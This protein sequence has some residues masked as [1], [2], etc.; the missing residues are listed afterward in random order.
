MAITDYFKS[1]RSITAEEVREFL[2]GK[3]PDDYNLVDVRQ[4]S[5]YEDGHIPGSRLIPL[6]ELKDRTAELDPD[7]PTIAY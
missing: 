7:K 6:G 4:V 5:E 2:K 3:N 1:I